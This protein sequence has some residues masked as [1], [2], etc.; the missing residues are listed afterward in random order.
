YFGWLEGLERVR[1]AQRLF[2]QPYLAA[3]GRSSTDA[4]L[5]ALRDFT[6]TGGRAGIYAGAYARYRPPGP[7]QVDATFNPDFSAVPPDRASTNLDRF[8]VSSPEAP[9]FFAE[10]R[11]R[12]EMGIPAAQLFYTRRVGLRTTVSGASE[13]VPI[14]YGAKTIVRDEGTQVAAMN[15]GLTGS[16]VSLDDNVTVLRF[17][18]SFDHGRRIGNLILY[19]DGSGG[20]YLSSGIDGAYTLLDEHLTAS[21]FYARSATQGKGSGGIGEADLG[22]A[23]EDY[24]AKLQYLDIGDLFDAQLGFVPLTGVRS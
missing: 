18:Q 8:E 9:P 6:G 5:P 3:F 11:P 12:F 7:L 10:D 4:P 21:G 1:P 19:R 17:N 13:E 22:W 20:R 23:T 14:L 2:V 16:R 24:N 15:V